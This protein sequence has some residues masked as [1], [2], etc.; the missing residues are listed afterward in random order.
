MVVGWTKLPQKQ[1]MPK[2]KTPPEEGGARL[3]GVVFAIPSAF[4]G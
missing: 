3:M 1:L 4:A 2:T